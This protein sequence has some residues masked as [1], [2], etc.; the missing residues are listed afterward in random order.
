M[1]PDV[2]EHALH[3]GN[4][5]FI[6]KRKVRRVIE[7]KNIPYTYVSAN[8]FAGFFAGSLGQLLDKSPKMPA[9]DKVLIYGDGNVKGNLVSSHE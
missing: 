8:M 6:D 2:M 4:S 1:D 7:A 9:R 3:P 5:I